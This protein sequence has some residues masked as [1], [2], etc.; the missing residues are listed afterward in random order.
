MINNVDPM[1]AKT[2]DKNRV[3]KLWMKIRS[4]PIMAHKLSE[5]IELDEIVLTQVLGFV[6]DEKTFN[7]LASMKTSY[8]IV[9][10]HILLCVRMFS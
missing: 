8:E 1:M 7:N 3:S 10:Q 9:W 5:C 2:R 6:E 4:S